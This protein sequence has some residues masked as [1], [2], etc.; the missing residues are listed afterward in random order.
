M[1][2]ADAGNEAFPRPSP[3]LDCAPL[4]SLVR[5][6]P[7]SQAQTLGPAADGS[8]PKEAEGGSRNDPDDRL[9]R[10]DERDVDRELVAPRQELARAVARVDDEGKPASSA[11]G[12]ARSS[13]ETTGTSGNRRDRPCG[14]TA[15]AASSA[16]LRGERSTLVRHATLDG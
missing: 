12:L 3:R 8:A 5:R 7:G 11:D 4:H 9:A 10:T 13:S 15:F 1:G 14:M 2:A 6:C 16:A